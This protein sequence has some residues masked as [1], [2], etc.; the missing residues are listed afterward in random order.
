MIVTARAGTTVAD[1]HAHLKKHGQ[2]TSLP[3]RGGTIGGAIA[4][5]KNDLNVRKGRVRD[6]VLQI[7]YISADG[8]IVSSEPRRKERISNLHKLFVGSFGTLGQLL[9]LLCERINTGRKQVAHS[10]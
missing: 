5:G 9:K 1:L 10:C 2:R 7:R 6:A 4:V 8:E 3:D